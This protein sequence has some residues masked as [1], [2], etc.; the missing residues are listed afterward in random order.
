MYR[1]IQTEYTC[2]IPLQNISTG[3]PL[4]NISTG[5]GQ[6]WD[7]LKKIRVRPGPTHPLPW[8]SRLC[9]MF[10]L[11]KAPKAMCCTYLILGGSSS[12]EIPTR[13]GNIIDLNLSYQ[14]SVRYRRQN[15]LKTQHRTTLVGDRAAEYFF[16][17]RWSENPPKQFCKIKRSRQNSCSRTRYRPEIYVCKIKKFTQKGIDFVNS[18]SFLQANCRYFR[19]HQD[20]G[21]MTTAVRRRT[22][23][24]R[25][26]G[27]GS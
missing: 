13:G 26:T 22:R 17:L 5:L 19:D 7:H 24:A 11:C 8:S 21:H 1:Y 12:E 23:E 3:I 20:C 2:G 4:Q 16:V 6:F 25:I 15:Q 14:Q 9:R 27:R 18:R 10:F